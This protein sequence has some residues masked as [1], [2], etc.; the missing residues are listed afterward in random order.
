[1]ACQK[2]GRF[3]F[4]NPCNEMTYSTQYLKYLRLWPHE[5][6]YDELN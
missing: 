2:N 1:M 6:L 5:R 4:E 3:A